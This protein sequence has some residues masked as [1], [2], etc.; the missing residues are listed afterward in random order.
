MTPVDKYIRKLL[1]EFDCVIIP[2]FGGILTHRIGVRYDETAR[3]F[4][5]SCKRLAFN[6]ILKIDDGLL[7]YYFAAGE[8]ISRDRAAEEIKKF[9]LSLRAE[10]ENQQM[11]SIDQIGSFSTNNEGK[12]IF[13][14][15][16]S[17]NYEQ[18]SF[19]FEEIKAEKSEWQPGWMNSMADS[20][21]SAEMVEVDEASI[22][23]LSSRNNLRW[24]WAAAVTLICAASAASYLYEPSDNSLLSSLDPVS[25]VRNIYQP[26]S[27]NGNEALLVEDGSVEF[28]NVKTVYFL[29]TLPKSTLPANEEE[30]LSEED[31]T[32]LAANSLREE[33]H[34]AVQPAE[35]YFLIA[36]S[37][38][39]QKN[40]RKLQSQLLRHGFAE[41]SVLSD[42][43]GKW[44]K[45]SAGSYKT[46][47]AAMQDKAKVD[48]LLSAESWVYHKK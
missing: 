48:G 9:V 17:Q 7:T 3:I 28:S 11:V 2:E 8:N 20:I 39:S 25:L 1:F 18:E 26:A 37:F 4:K 10:L 40:A 27:G 41:A 36:G 23:P 31:P 47:D 42:T 6:E 5:P 38:G 12:L 16:Y 44:V 21:E 29:E 46:H 13:E 24:G 32:M 30:N 22:V 14:P 45:V 33:Q 15:D 19:G 34:T 43:P 35:D